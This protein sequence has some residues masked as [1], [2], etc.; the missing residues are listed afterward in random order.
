MGWSSI[1]WFAVIALAVTSLHA[2]EPTEMEVAEQ[3]AAKCGYTQIGHDGEGHVTGLQ[4][5]NRKAYVE[6]PEWLGTKV[7]EVVNPNGK[8]LPQLTDADLPWLLKLPHLKFLKLDGMLITGRGYW[9]LAA[10]TQLEYLGLHHI[11]RKELGDTLDP[12]CPLVANEL[13]NLRRFDYKHNFRMRDV[14]VG[15]LRGSAKL[16]YLHLDNAC[17][18]SSIVAFIIACPN[19]T[20][21]ELHRTGISS[22]DLARVLQAN[23]KITDIRIR[24]RDAKGLQPG[25]L[26]QLQALPELKNLCF[27]GHY[28]SMVFTYQDDLAPLTRISTLRTIV[29]P[30]KKVNDPVFLEWVKNCPSVDVKFQYY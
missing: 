20:R 29:A 9:S 17:C 6:P 27:G 11:D 14:P 30:V 12:T 22:A 18:E 28:N 25:D 16:E 23:P 13:P 15:K 19:L 7:K 3:L 21:L 10:L 26:K 24:P 8:D 5:V 2:A 1:G 4:F